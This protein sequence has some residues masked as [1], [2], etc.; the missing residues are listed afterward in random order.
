MAHEVKI[1]AAGES[2]NS[3]T[4]GKWHKAN[5]EV[6]TKGELLASIETDKVSA[7][8]EAE[9]GGTLKIVVPEGEEVA[10]GTVVA[11]I[12]E[13][14]EAPATG[15]AEPGPVAVAPAAELRP[16]TGGGSDQPDEESEV[17]A[18]KVPAAGEAIT[19]ATIAQWHKRDGAGVREGETLVTLET[20]KVSA[21]L[22]AEADGV[23]CILSPEGSEVSIGAVIGTITVGALSALEPEAS[24]PVPLPDSAPPIEVALPKEEPAPLPSAVS[25]APPRPNPAIVASAPSS[26]LKPD[27]AVVPEPSPRESSPPVFD[28]RTTR[29]RLSS[30][31]RKI[32]SQLVKAQQTAAILTTFNEVDMSAIIQLR[33]TVQESFIEKY[34]VKLGFMSLFVKAT[35]LALKEVPSVNGR[36]DGDEV[37]QNHFYDIGIAVG[38]EKG[39]VVP[40]VREAN[41]KSCAEIEHDILDYANRAREG[42]IQLEDL[43]GGVFTI[44]NGGIYG[45][46]LSTPILNAPQSGILGMHT[47]QDRP[48]AID[49]KVEVRP[50]MYLAMSYD[51]RLVDG[52]EAV[53]FLIKVKECLESPASLLLEL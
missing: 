1:P 34:G 41:H 42:K 14:V 2:I 23:I 44:S 19:S 53:T 5:G 30:L 4:I 38:I 25:V 26:M 6:V 10:I 24:S 47:I 27:L 43:Q 11:E 37:V 18:I 8:L 35:V 49:G 32:A 17:I 52:R 20:D 45:S 51:H 22:D 40:V 12:E 31:R 28:G 48:I 39:L 36:I 50:M 3:A 21:E 33:K 46:L 13:E 9:L 7:E 16:E 29:K 15:P